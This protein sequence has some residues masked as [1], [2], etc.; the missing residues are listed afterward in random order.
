M[1]RSQKLHNAV[2]SYCI[3]CHAHWC[4]EYQ[5]L[6][7]KDAGRS[8]RMYTDEAFNT[9]PRYNILSAILT[10]IERFD[11][12][13]LFELTEL[14]DLFILSGH[15]APGVFTEEPSSKIEAA[16]I[17]D[18]RQRFADAVSRFASGQIP[19]PPPLP[20]RRVLSPFA[21]KSLWERDEARWGSTG[22]RFYS[23]AES[24]D[25]SLSAF[26]ATA[27]H[28]QFSQK[29][30]R[31][32]FAVRA[33]SR[34]FELRE[35]GDSNYVLST[36]AREPHYDRVEGFWFTESLDWIM[37]ASHERSITT[38][39]TLTASV[40]RDCPEASEHRWSI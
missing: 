1:N 18:E 9:F 25:P 36:D 11:P 27:F 10:D 33:I 31:P 13:A 15:I 34:L 8:G 30:S 12:D 35:Y 7:D 21:V 32:F 23:L 28:R 24:T 4:T 37:Y 26:D 6:I 22:S 39:C 19:D 38:G 5:A 40:G 29:T 20:Y 3:T 2:R 17:A 16:A 14:T